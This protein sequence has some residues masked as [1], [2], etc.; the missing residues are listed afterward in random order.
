LASRCG[1]IRAIYF[2]ANA[3]K[4]LREPRK[5]LYS[6]RFPQ[7][8]VRVVIAVAVIVAAPVK[9]GSAESVRKESD[10]KVETVAPVKPG[11]GHSV[12][13]GHASHVHRE[14]DRRVRRES[15]HRGK[16]ESDHRGKA[17][18]DR[19]AS[20]VHRERDRRVRKESEDRD[21]AERDP[22]VRRE[23]EAHELSRLQLL[24]QLL[25]RRQPF[26]QRQSSRRHQW[27]RSC[28]QQRRLRASRGDSKPCYW[29]RH[30]QSTADSIAVA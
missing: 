8:N 27:N 30:V 3:A 2:P 15:D 5:L 26:S 9:V 22:H 16:A 20:H 25:R 1:F 4:Q 12:H 21:K 19:H 6:Q 23:S 11:R 24:K 29:H 10:H 18:R 17:E 13:K 14:R 28:R 7:E